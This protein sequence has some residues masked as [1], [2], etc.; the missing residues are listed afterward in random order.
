MV[1]LAYGF[2]GPVL[3]DDSHVAVNHLLLSRPL[4]ATLFHGRRW[5]PAPPPAEPPGQPGT[6]SRM[7]MKQ[8]LA[9]GAVVR[10]FGLGTFLLP[11]W[12]TLIGGLG[13]YDA[14]WLDAEHVGLNH[15][16]MSQAAL[17]D[18][19]RFKNGKPMRRGQA[20][21]VSRTAL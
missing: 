4:V 10:F 3:L 16:Q 6:L 19:Q 12:I 17:A 8:K 21:M 18:W 7:G 11:E 14:V 15:A 9:G 2:D 13:D 1:V 5:L 20:R